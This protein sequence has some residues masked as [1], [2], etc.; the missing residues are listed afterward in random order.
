MGALRTT[1]RIVAV[2]FR[3]K[4]EYR[5]DFALGIVFGILWQCSILV[6]ATVL[7]N[8]FPGLGGWTKGQVLLIASMRL[9]SHGFY[10]LFFLNVY[11]LPVLV[12]EGRI[13]GFMLRPMP[14][15]RQVLLAEMHTNAFGDLSVALVLFGLSVS[16]TGVHWSVMNVALVLAGIVGGT[17]VEAAAITTVCS[18]ALRTAMSG[19]WSRWIDE[20]FATFGNYPL[21]IL[22]RGAAV[23]LTYVVPVAFVAY[24]PAAA[25]TGHRESSVAPAWL[26]MASP[27]VGFGLFLIAKR[28]WSANLKRYT[29]VGG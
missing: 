22:P 5:T 15:Y 29:G 28:V 11:W 25:L 7:I 24:L 9:L 13:E 26:I 6:F 18:F 10:T 19:A 17:L 2:N 16:S 3:A 27:L 21:K 1:A 14:V 20:L 23:A 8:R 12:A 4:L